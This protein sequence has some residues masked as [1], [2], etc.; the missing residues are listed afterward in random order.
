[1]DD[2]PSYDFTH[3]FLSEFSDF[4]KTHNLLPLDL[5]PDCDLPLDVFLSDAKTRSFE[6]ICNTNDD[7]SW[8]EALASPECEYWIA[9]AR[10]EL[11]S[12]QDLQVFILVPCS[13][14]PKGKHLLKGKL[15]CK[16]KQDDTG[17]VVG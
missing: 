13:E 15:V 7:P 5:P 14:V 11:W 6:P 2:L 16:W 12:L 3:T 4:R 17:K 10:D 8:Q 9:G 1:M